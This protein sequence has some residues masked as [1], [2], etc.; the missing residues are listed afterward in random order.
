MNRW[1]NLL[2]VTLICVSMFGCSMCCGPYDFDYPTFGGKYQR[3][4]PSYGRVGSVFSDPNANAYGPS[5]DSNL[6]VSGLQREAPDPLDDEEPQDPDL[7]DDPDMSE[8]DELDSGFDESIDDLERELDE[9]DKPST[10]P[11]PNVE[12]DADETTASRMN[13]KRPTRSS[14][15]R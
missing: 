7:L 12:P 2:F 13:R 15:W 10:L 4:N 11:E 6:S 14:A 8:P 9:L 3:T 5:A 1:I